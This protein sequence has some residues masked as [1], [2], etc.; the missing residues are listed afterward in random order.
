[1]GQGGGGGLQPGSASEKTL[2][3]QMMVRPDEIAVRIRRA[4]KEGRNPSRLLRCIDQLEIALGHRGIRMP[5]YFS[6]L[7]QEAARAL[8]RSSFPAAQSGRSTR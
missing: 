2:L 6:S 8:G 7:R 1:M 3:Q 5:R 4:L